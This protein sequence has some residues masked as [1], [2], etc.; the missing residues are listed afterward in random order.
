MTDIICLHLNSLHVD[1]E[2]QRAEA[3]LIRCMICVMEYPVAESESEEDNSYLSYTH[4]CWEHAM[5][6]IDMHCI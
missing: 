6:S 3:H 2:I 4:G 5:D 1:S